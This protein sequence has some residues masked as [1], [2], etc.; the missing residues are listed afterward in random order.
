MRRSGIQLWKWALPTASVMLLAVVAWLWLGHGPDGDETAAPGHG[1]V[2]VAAGA[3]VGA[4]KAEQES[5]QVDMG[6]ASEKGE[7]GVS[8]DSAV[9]E[10]S[11]PADGQSASDAADERDE[12][13][14]DA[15]DGLTDKWRAPSKAVTEGDI[16]RFREQFAKVPK[17]RREE[18]LQRA[19]N[20][21]PD[22]NAMLLVGILLD[23]EQPRE[24]LEQVF[25]DVLN[26]DETVKMPILRELFK[27]REH[28]CWA[29]VAW[30][31]D[32][33]GE[34]PVGK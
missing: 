9:A 19:L 15:F 4:A 34:I 1:G 20:L 27:D 23:K 22:E 11:A 6:I 16:V 28:P 21:V 18:C 30:I 24:T 33:T 31:L 12:K 32:A 29:D 7:G 2:E 13:L 5:R 26:R 14:V 25:N 10:P 8:S 17:S 3:K